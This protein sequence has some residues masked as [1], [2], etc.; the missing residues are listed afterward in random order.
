LATYNGAQF[1]QDQVSS[2]LNQQGVDVRLVIRDDGSNDGTNDLLAL[3][4]REN[5]EHVRIVA[6][7]LGPSG[8]AST[9]FGHLLRSH[10][11]GQ[12]A[13]IALADQDDVWFPD[14]LA[15]AI[16]QM[17]MSEADAYSSNL[18][19]FD[20]GNRAAWMVDKAAPAKPL[21]YLF[22]GAS[23]GCTYVMT[24]RAVQAV[25]A[26]IG[27]LGGTIPRH[28]SH[29]WLIY[30]CCRAENLK[31]LFDGAARIAYRQHALNVYGTSSG[32][33][34]I[35]ERSARLRSGWYRQHVIFLRSALQVSPAADR[36]L[37]RVER[38][39]FSDRIWLAVHA[40]DLR[41]DKR[42]VMQL[43]IALLSGLF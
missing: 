33:A 31:W 28:I 8:S 3:L 35:V 2:I 30:A 38:L 19:A 7:D 4:A 29:D 22:Q 42:D 13:W 20:D 1:I 15:R 34:R 6:D 32:I 16:D 37:R 10:V 12:D 26:C 11:A 17:I 27:K 23:A 39:S 25:Q 9:N 36:V 21:D 5:P 18:L 40:A 41:R 43:R 14:K 24:A